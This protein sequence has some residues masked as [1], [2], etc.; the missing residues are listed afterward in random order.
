MC[1]PLRA[2]VVLICLAAPTLASARPGS[3]VR[4]FGER[5]AVLGP[6]GNHTEDKQLLAVGVQSDGKIVAASHHGLVRHLPDGSVDASFGTN[7]VVPLPAVPGWPK[8]VVMPG[9][10]VLVARGQGET[11]AIARYESDGTL[12]PSF[13]TSGVVVTTVLP[14]NLTQLAVQQDGKI[15]IAGGG[16]WMSV[17]RL[18]ADGSIDATFGTGGIASHSTA[19]NGVTALALQPDGAIVVGADVT[20]VVDGGDWV[21]TRYDVTGQVDPSFGVGGLVFADPLGGANDVI[22]DILVQD[23]GVVAVGRSINDEYWFVLARYVDGVLDPLFGVLGVAQ[24]NFVHQ[25]AGTNE[26]PF[27]ALTD[28]DGNLVVIGAVYRT[29]V[30][31]GDYDTQDFF[32][33]VR[34]EPN[35]T[36][37][38]NFGTGGGV[39]SFPDDSAH[40]YAGAV[41]PDG[42]L[43][44]VGSAGPDR[45]TTG[46]A[47]ARYEGAGADL[48]RCPH[49]RDYLCHELPSGAAGALAMT[50]GRDQSDMKDGLSWQWKGLGASDFGDPTTTESYALCV[51]NEDEE[52][53]PPL[54]YAAPIPAGGTCS[55][56]PCWKAGPGGIKYG[57]RDGAPGG[58]TSLTLKQSGGK[59]TIALKGRGAHLGGINLLPVDFPI[60]VQLRNTSGS[61]WS[62]VFANSATNTREKL[63]AKAFAP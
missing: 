11:W 14:G 35:G 21:L 36:L 13:G 16:G 7:G 23:D 57:S 54:R 30:T 56:K 52:L 59:T 19:S 45:Y 49:T 34:F 33:L 38:A 62:S 44:V 48:P 10:E 58:V 37:D 6:L 50:N 15:L 42:T 17:L 61:C 26:V 31:S 9:D 27:D 18:D 12:D 53:W 29:V 28:T 43:V 51:Y 8:I 63:K 60:V 55:G 47:L 20:N 5:G 41:A 39:M 22:T 2:V 24:A 32:T 3:L 46:F 40:A 1:H 4:S 25:G